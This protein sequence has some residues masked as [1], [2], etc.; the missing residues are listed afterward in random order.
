MSVVGEL[1]WGFLFYTNSIFFGEGKKTN[2]YGRKLTISPG[3]WT[4]IWTVFYLC[5]M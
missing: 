4:E 3:S 2:F 5:F 1:I